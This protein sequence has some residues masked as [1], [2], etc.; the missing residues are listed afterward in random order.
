MEGGSLF[1]FLNQL[2]RISDGSP[3][4]LSISWRGGRVSGCVVRVRG[5]CVCVRGWRRVSGQ[6]AVSQAGRDRSSGPIS[7]TSPSSLCPQPRLLGGQ[8]LLS[9]F[10]RGRQ[11]ILQVNTAI[12]NGV[13]R[14]GKR[15][16]GGIG[17]CLPQ[18][19]R[20]LRQDQGAGGVPEGR[21]KPGNSVWARERAQSPRRERQRTS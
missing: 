4:G 10:L 21:K 1:P 15:G 7:N 6:T 5:R 12:N 2:R 20:P 19:L 14:P 18:A 9:L 11:S 8:G 17:L 16:R 13:R 3:W